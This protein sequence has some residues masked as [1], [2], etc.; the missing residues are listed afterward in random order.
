MWHI[1][2]MAQ[3]HHL[4]FSPKQNTTSYHRRNSPRRDINHRIT[5]ATHLKWEPKDA[6]ALPKGSNALLCEATELI[7]AKNKILMMQYIWQRLYFIPSKI[8]SSAN[9]DWKFQLLSSKTCSTKFRKHWTPFFHVF[10]TLTVSTS[11]LCTPFHSGDPCRLVAGQVL[12]SGLLVWCVWAQNKVNHGFSDGLPWFTKQSGGHVFIKLLPSDRTGSF[13]F[14]L[15]R[16]IRQKVSIQ[17]HSNFAGYGVVRPSP[18]HS[19]I[20]L[21]RLCPFQS[22]AFRFDIWANT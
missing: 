4:S 16:Q 17:Y 2:H 15:W 13:R 9:A 8:D 12:T 7:V 22:P 5:S 10:P 11:H 18:L 20:E 19:K 3:T 14:D 21:C 1:R 6:D